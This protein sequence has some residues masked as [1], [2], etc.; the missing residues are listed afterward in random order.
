MYKFPDKI[1]LIT[2]EN[3]NKPLSLTI[4]MPWHEIEL[5]PDSNR[6]EFKNLL[7]KAKKFLISAGASE[8]EIKKTLKPALKMVNDLDF[9][10]NRQGT[11]VLFLHPNFFRCYIIPNNTVS[12]L[13]TIGNRFILKPFLEVIKDNLEFFVLALSHNKVSLYKGD[14]YKL[15]VVPIKG[16]PADMKKTLRIDEYP[17]WRETHAIAPASFGKGSEGVHGQYNIRQV[18]KDYLLEFFRIIDKRLHKYFLTIKAPL[19]IGGVGYLLPIYRKV[20][21][22]K[23]LVDNEIKGN[24]DYSKLDVIRASALSILV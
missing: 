9:W 6:I 19:I 10:Q 2:L 3:F 1:E 14:K 11:V 24:L 12:Q 18:D 5:S 17:K 21:S 20:N 16:F 15:E 7:T 23:F 4:Y 22:Y 8:K 13:I